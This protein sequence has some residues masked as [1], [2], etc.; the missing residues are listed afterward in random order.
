MKKPEAGIGSPEI[1]LT[2]IEGEVRELG[3]GGGKLVDRPD[4]AE[5]AFDLM[6]GAVEDA[7][8]EMELSPDFHLRTVEKHRPDGRPN[9]QLLQGGGEG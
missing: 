4:V 2:A 7:G 6:R 3:S 9:L 8:G 5:Y 1:K